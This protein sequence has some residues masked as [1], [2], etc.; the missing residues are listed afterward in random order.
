M[1]AE[2]VQYVHVA[3]IG[4][5]HGVKGFVKL[6]THTEPSKNFFEYARL[7]LQEG[8]AYVPFHYVDKHLFNNQKIIIRID[9]VVTPEA[10][11]QYVHG[12]IYVLRSDLPEAPDGQYYWHDLVGLTLINQQ[13]QV[14]GVVSYLF[15]N[16]ANDVMVLEGA[17]Q[18]MV[19]FIPHVIRCVDLQ[20]KEI[21]VDWEV[22]C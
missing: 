5:P 14:L 19:P 22:L 11:Q 3:T 15:N 13:G 1:S 10:A 18:V 12:K 17:K 9:G 16:G 6:N 20:R 21:L 4:A 2:S 7:F 8:R